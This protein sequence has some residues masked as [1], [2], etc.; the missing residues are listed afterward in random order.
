MYLV[1]IAWRIRSLH[2]FPSLVRRLS[3][4]FFIYILLFS[5]ALLGGIETRDTRRST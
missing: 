2:F 4:V 1:V 5:L 3:I